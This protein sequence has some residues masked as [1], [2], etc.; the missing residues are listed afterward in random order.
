MEG[1]VFVVK[2]AIKATSHPSRLLCKDQW[3][4]LIHPRLTL[5]MI[6]ASCLLLPKDQTS[7]TSG[8][9]WH[10]RLHVC[11]GWRG[12][13]E[14]SDRLFITMTL[15]TEPRQQYNNNWHPSGTPSDTGGDVKE[16]VCSENNWNVASLQSLLWPHFPQFQI[17]RTHPHTIP[18]PP[19]SGCHRHFLQCFSCNPY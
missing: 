1:L 14:F 12:L 16:T 4:N 6:S 17:N 19:F 2:L 11:S 18:V 10:C 13:E 8:E 9:P 3:C 7:V 15:T 5:L